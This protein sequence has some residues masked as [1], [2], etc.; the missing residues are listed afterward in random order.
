MCI[1]D[2]AY[3]EDMDGNQLTTGKTMKVLGFYFSSDPTVS[4][5]VEALCRRFRQKY[6]ILIHLRRYGFSEEELAR[7][8]KTIVRPM[9][10]FCSVLYHPMLTDQLDERLDRCQLHALRCIY[11]Q[12]LSYSE[13]RARAGVTTD[14]QVFVM[15]LNVYLHMELGFIYTGDGHGK[16]DIY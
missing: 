16:Q 8:Y 12:G 2:R 10:D 9:A 1:R 15:V 11:G 13:M 5:H 3:I 14:T 4:H 7:V 6:W